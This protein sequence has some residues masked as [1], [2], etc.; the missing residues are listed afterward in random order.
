MNIVLRVEGMSCGH[1]VSAITA[2]VQPLPG[3]ASVAVDLAAGTVTVAGTAD[4]ALDPQ[5][6]TT[7]IEDCGYDVSRAA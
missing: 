1:C 5:A 4:P 2:A 3:V 7:A 6:V